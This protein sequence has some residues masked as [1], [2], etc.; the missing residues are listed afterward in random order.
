MFSSLQHSIL[1]LTPLP[2]LYNLEPDLHITDNQYNI[3]LTIFFFSYAIFEVPSNVFL[4]RLRPS[5]WLSG[6]MLC[7]GI[8]MTLQGVVHNYGG[9]LGMRWLLGM[10]EAGLFP[11]VNY[12]LSWF[13]RLLIYHL[14]SP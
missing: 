9:L 1:S 13:D 5:I 14:C 12:Y 11:G 8:M 4:K 6:L 10:F 3:A 7:W 2:Q